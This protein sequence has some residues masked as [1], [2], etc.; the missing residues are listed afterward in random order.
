MSYLRIFYVVHSSPLIYI[1]L[2]SLTG[3]RAVN[4]AWLLLLLLLLLL[5]NHSSQQLVVYTFFCPR[6]SVNS[7][8]LA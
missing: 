7:L 1:C 4:S 2:F 5:F 8:L 6:T 3:L